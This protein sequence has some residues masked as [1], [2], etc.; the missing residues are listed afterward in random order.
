MYTVIRKIE[1]QGF[2]QN[3]HKQDPIIRLSV[4]KCPARPYLGRPISCPTPRFFLPAISPPVLR[5]GPDPKRSLSIF[6]PQIL[7]TPLNPATL[8][9]VLLKVPVSASLVLLFNLRLVTVPLRRCQCRVCGRSL[10][11][12][13][14]KC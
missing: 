5:K 4:L 14:P 12:Y 3:S 6:P 10:F 13:V 9:F 7:P 2:A 1:H 11:L 8:F